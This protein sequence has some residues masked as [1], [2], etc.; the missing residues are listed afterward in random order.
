MTDAV[1]VE[2]AQQALMLILL[3]TAP[4]LLMGLVVGLVISIFQAAT[5][6]QDQMIT[7]V[8]RMVAVFLVLLL[9]IP[10]YIRMLTAYTAELYSRVP[11]V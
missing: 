6:I 5:Q 7:F 4:P 2:L 9:L 10:W 8:P 1:A 3:L 11:A